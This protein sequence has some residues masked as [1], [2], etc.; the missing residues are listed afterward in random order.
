[1]KELCMKFMEAK[2]REAAAKEERLR[3][4]AELLAAVKPSKLEGTETRATDGFKVSVTTKLNRS[5]DFDAYRAMDLPENM[6]FVEFKPSINLKNLRMIE[7]L[8]PAL[9]AQ[10]VTVKPAKPSIKIEEVA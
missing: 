7:R 3:A 9:V 4:E 10:C 1:M 5:L 8:D 2:A 6:A